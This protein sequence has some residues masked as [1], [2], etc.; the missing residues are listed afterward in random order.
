MIGFNC[1]IKEHAAETESP[2]SLLDTSDLTLEESTDCTSR[3]IS[4]WL[5]SP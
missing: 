4:E 5:P 1:W 2:M 3:W